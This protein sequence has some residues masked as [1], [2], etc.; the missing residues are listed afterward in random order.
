MKLYYVY[1]LVNLMGTVE[2]VGKTTNPKVRIKQHTM[3]KANTP[4]GRGKFFRRQDITM[5]IVSQ[6]LTDKEARKYEAEL[7]KSWGLET[8]GEVISR[9]NKGKLSGEKCNFSKLTEKQ[10]NEILVLLE[11]K[12][13]QNKIAQK[14]KVGQP[15]ISRIKNGK[16]W[17][18]LKQ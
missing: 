8:E 16:R 2:Y 4:T 13:S 10:V 3:W 15:V 12:V 14:F 5:H 11:Q 7:Q 1:E 6:H 18:Y 17:S 9:K